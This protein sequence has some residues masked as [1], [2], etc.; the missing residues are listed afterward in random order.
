MDELFDL[1]AGHLAATGELAQ[2]PLA[3]GAGFVDHVAALLLGHRQLG[4]G[5]GGGVLA[6]AGSFDLGFLAHPLGLVGGLAQHARRVLLGADLDLRG[7][8]ACGGEDARRLLAEQPGDDFFVE[9]DVGVRVTAL[10]RA[11][12]AL[13]ELLP[14]LQPGQFGGDH[15]QE[16]AHIGL[17]EPLARRRERRGG[18]RRRR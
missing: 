4:F 18:N 13:E 5:I 14:L 11:Q 15:A 12:L 16:V 3:V 8:L 7:G 10:G 9:C 1:L 2:H 6:T 17:L